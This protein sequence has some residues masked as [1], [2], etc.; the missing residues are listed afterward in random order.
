MNKIK[1]Q[2]CSP[3][4]HLLV[5]RFEQGILVVSNPNAVKA[6]SAS[7]GYVNVWDLDEI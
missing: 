4:T 7:S 5:V 1:E 3:T 2:Y 6:N